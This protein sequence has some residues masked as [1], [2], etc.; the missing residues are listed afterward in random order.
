MFNYNPTFDYDDGSCIPF[1]SG[2]TD[3]NAFNYDVDANVDNG[4]CEYVNTDWCTYQSSQSIELDQGWNMWSTYLCLENPEDIPNHLSELEMIIMKDENG[5]VYWPQFGLNSITPGLVGGIFPGEGFQIKMEIDQTL[6]LSGQKASYYTPITTSNGWNLIGVVNEIPY[7]LEDLMY[8]YLNL[9]NGCPEELTAGIPIVETAIIIKDEVG[10]V[11][12]PAF[13]LN[14]LAAGSGFMMPGEGYQLRQCNTADDELEWLYNNPTN[15]GRYSYT[16]DDIA[17]LS[18][19]L[20]KVINTGN[21]LTLAIPNEIWLSQPQDGDE[22]IIYDQTGL[23][24]GNAPYRE[25]GTVVT[26]WGD[27]ETTEEKDGLF[28]GEEFII[29]LF[30]SNEN[31]TEVINIH[32]WEEGSGFYSVNGISIAG[33]LSQET[34]EERRLVRI[35]DILGREISHEFN[36]TTVIYIYSDGSTEKR[37]LL[38]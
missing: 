36:N 30:R 12:F 15:S 21:N 19:N 28:V 26:I 16:E 6:E 37:H 9:D 11:Y 23:L 4:L 20:K 29:K 31:I 8:T 38:K 1:I 7:P 2:C 32:Q 35:T 18:N 22:I 17:M 10:A 5:A 33:S 25:Q 24:V 27:D 13:G 3:S 14:D 34:I